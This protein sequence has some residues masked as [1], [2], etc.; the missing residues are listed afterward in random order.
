MLISGGMA[1]PLQAP[2]CVGNWGTFLCNRHEIV[3]VSSG[4][5]DRRRFLLSTPATASG[6]SISRTDSPCS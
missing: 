1:S 3:P 2:A 6:G 5:V 4:E